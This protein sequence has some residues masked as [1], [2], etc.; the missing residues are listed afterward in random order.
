MGSRDTDVRTGAQACAL[1]HGRHAGRRVWAWSADEHSGRRACRGYAAIFAQLHMSA[2]VFKA[3]QSQLRLPMFRQVSFQ[4][5]ISEE[6]YACSVTQKSFEVSA[7]LSG[8][9]LL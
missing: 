4:L 2:V 3:M 7:W 5:C 9:N 1:E 8:T 6:S